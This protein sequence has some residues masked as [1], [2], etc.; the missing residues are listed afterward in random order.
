MKKKP[1]IIGL[2]VFVVLLA[3]GSVYISF[4]LKELETTLPEETSALSYTEACSSG[5]NNGYLFVCESSI[6]GCGEGRLRNCQDMQCYNSNWAHA[7]A[8]ILNDGQSCAGLTDLGGPFEDGKNHFVGCRYP[9]GQAP[10]NCFC[11]QG[12]SGTTTCSTD[13]YG[14]GN[15]YDSCGARYRPPTTTTPPTRTPT[16]T[17]TFTPTGILTI[18]PTLTNTPSFTPTLTITGTITTTVTITITHTPTHTPTY[19]PS[20]T[21]TTTLTPTLTTTLTPTITTTITTTITNSPTITPTR[22][23]TTTL[24]PTAIVTDEVDRIII[25]MCFMFVGFLLYRSGAYIIIGNSIWS[26]GGK[27]LFNTS[28]RKLNK[29]TSF[30]EKTIHNFINVTD[31]FIIFNVSIANNIQRILGKIINSIKTSIGLI[32]SDIGL[33]DKEKFEKRLLKRKSKTEK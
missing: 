2:S 18:T 32:L 26:Y 33:K 13:S 20:F 22:P 21:P 19:T 30:L 24:P 29:F 9:S 3:L 10:Q 12:M 17:P 8:P 25:G 14:W 1:F 31:D 27:S 6:S 7:C 15:T 23:L 4:R 28:S 5:Q 16:N 11:L